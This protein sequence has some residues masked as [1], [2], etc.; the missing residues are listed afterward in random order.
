[1]RSVHTLTE[2]RNILDSPH[3][4]Q[5]SSSTKDLDY[6]LWLHFLCDLTPLPPPPPLARH[7]LL[8]VSLFAPSLSS[9]LFTAGRRSTPFLISTSGYATSCMRR[10]PRTNP[11]SFPPMSQYTHTHTDRLL[12]YF[13]AHLI[14]LQG[15]A[16]MREEIKP[17]I[18]YQG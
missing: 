15:Q 5:L 11:I 4:L 6:K 14:K 12:W 8:S 18:T 3:L 2:L 13:A 10:P 7:S 17:V 1:M 16:H 9:R